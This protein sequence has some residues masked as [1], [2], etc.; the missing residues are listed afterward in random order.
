VSPDPARLALTVDLEFYDT[1]YGFSDDRP[2]PTPESRS[3]GVDGVEFVASL[4]EAHDARGTFFVLGEIAEERPALIADLA[5]R[6]HEIA[7][8]GYS[9]SH[10]DL[11][12]Q[13]RSVVVEELESSK[14]VLEDATGESVEGFRAP[15]FSQDEDVLAALADVGYRYDSSVVPGRSIPGFYGVPDAPDTPYVVEHATAADLLELPVS[16]APWTRLPVSGA[17][18]RLLGRR[19]AEWG[20]RRRLASDGYAMLYV[21]P[22]E[23]V[24]VPHVEGIPRR[25]P[26]R[27]GE[28]ARRTLESI[29]ETHADALT[30]AGE[31]AA[32]GPDRDGR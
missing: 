5:D 29:A 11:R 21:H 1:V 3:L 6:G 32:N 17:W 2:D 10:P 7:S 26:F 16:V 15:A 4:L 30:T 19:Y 24:D 9:K 22:W 25:V 18:M 13:P 28:H 20:V 23:L 31:I 27:T 12:E 8:H 14:A